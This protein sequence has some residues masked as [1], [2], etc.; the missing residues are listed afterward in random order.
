[1]MD[2]EGT[3]PRTLE[4]AR[5]IAISNGVRYAYTGN[6]HDREGGSTRCRECSALLIERDWY[7]LG[8]Y[9]VTD[10]GHCGSCGATLPGRFDG[11]RGAWGARRIPVR[12][13]DYRSR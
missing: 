4:R 13:A 11:G 5:K 12:L 1:M 8:H 3:P 6:V 7:E 10:D 9:N 2:I